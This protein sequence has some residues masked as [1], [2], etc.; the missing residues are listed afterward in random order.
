MGLLMVTVSAQNLC[1]FCRK[2]K[3]SKILLVKFQNQLKTDHLWQLISFVYTDKLFRPWQKVKRHL[4]PSRKYN[5]LGYGTKLDLFLN[6]FV[7]KFHLGILKI[8]QK[9][10]IFGNLSLL[11][12]RTDYSDPGKKL[13]DTCGLPENIIF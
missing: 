12:I 4:W 11:F 2:I 13:E 9:F 1:R 3:F 7:E 5:I 8:S 6:D 10:I